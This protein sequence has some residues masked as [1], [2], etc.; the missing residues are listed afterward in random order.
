MSAG[1][2]RAGCR[3]VAASDLGWPDFLVPICTI[4]SEVWI[5]HDETRLF[6]CKETTFEV[7]EVSIYRAAHA[8]AHAHARGWSN[9]TRLSRLRTPDRAVGTEMNLGYCSTCS[10]NNLS[11]VLGSEIRRP[12]RV[13]LWHLS[14]RLQQTRPSNATW[15]PEASRAGVGFILLHMSAATRDSAYQVSA[16]HL[17]LLFGRPR[18][19]QRE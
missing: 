13:F 11:V 17:T 5:L 18:G 15:N 12:A 3:R 2:T 10:G 6:S 1:R 7:V 19:R 14:A 9:S 16:S 8:H 4:K